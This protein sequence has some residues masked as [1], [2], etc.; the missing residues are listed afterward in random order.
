VV[1]V[2]QFAGMQNGKAMR[3]SAVKGAR[4]VLAEMHGGVAGDISVKRVGKNLVI[5]QQKAGVEPASVVIEEFYGSEGQLVGLGADGE[6]LE[7]LAAGEGGATEASAMT[8]GASAQLTLAAGQP[9]VLPSSFALAEGRSSVFSSALAGVSALAAGVALSNNKSGG[10][11][12]QPAPAASAFVLEG[13]PADAA[14][15]NPR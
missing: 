10:S 14:A 11:K 6:Y 7:Y 2:Q 15:G 8:D 12:A 5:E 9:V 13:Q 4:Y 1:H 3:I